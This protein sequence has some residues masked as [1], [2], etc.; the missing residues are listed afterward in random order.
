ML[1]S[2]KWLSRHIDLS[3]IE[4]ARVAAD[5]TLSTAE[6]EGL[7]EYLPH[8]REIVVG[9][10]LSREKHPDAER[11]SL[12]QVDIGAGAPLS[13]VCGAQNVAQGQ[14]VPVALPGT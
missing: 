8:A 1:I 6:V 2:F 10:V 11:L 7:E 5:L 12:C 13:I 14:T 9:R 3:G 4:P